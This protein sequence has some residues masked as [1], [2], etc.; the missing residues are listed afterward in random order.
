MK[1]LYHL[2]L[3]HVI[4]TSG[5]FSNPFNL[6]FLSNRFEH[7][8]IL[9]EEDD[10][11]DLFRGIKTVYAPDYRIYMNVSSND[12]IGR[13]KREVCRNY[14]PE[15]FLHKC[16][17]R[18]K[19]TSTTSYNILDNLDIDKDLMNIPQSRTW[20]NFSDYVDPDIRREHDYNLDSLKNSTNVSL[21][22]NDFWHKEMSTQEIRK[23]QGKFKFCYTEGIQ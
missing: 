12:L 20:M 6:P 21:D 11:R 22:L 10:K 15:I 14:Q 7:N 5:V 4:F 18:R 2:I 16:N 3:L 13:E 8:D 17:E 1:Q 19:I 23:I 9:L